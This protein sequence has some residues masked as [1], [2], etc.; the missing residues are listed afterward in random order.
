MN[1]IA[2][3]RTIVEYHATWSAEDLARY[4]ADPAAFLAD[5]DA[6][7]APPAAPPSLP[8]SHRSVKR[9]A[10]K[11]TAK[12]AARKGNGRPNGIGKSDSLEKIPCTICGGAVARKFMALHLKRRHPAAAPSA[13]TVSESKR[14]H[15]QTSPEDAELPL[16]GRSRQN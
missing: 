4:R 11:R 8:A 16:A 1:I 15:S 12:R 5:V 13:P 14:P 7:L 2:Q 10:H 6:Q 3:P 9:V